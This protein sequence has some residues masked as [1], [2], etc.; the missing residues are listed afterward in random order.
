MISS[1]KEAKQKQLNP[2]NMLSVSL[3][4]AITLMSSANRA[5][6]VIIDMTIEK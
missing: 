4:V 6:S 5:Y 1:E 3:S 2:Q